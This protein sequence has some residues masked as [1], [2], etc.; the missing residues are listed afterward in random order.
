M[1]E[2]DDAVRELDHVVR[3]R[4]LERVA[5][6][7]GGLQPAVRAGEQ[8]RRA[9]S[10]PAA[11]E[12]SADERLQRLR[13]RQRLR[14]IDVRAER[15]GELEREERVPAR[16]LVEAE[17]RRP[18]EHAAE[19]SLQDRVQ[20][21]RAERADLHALEPLVVDRE[22]ELRHRD[23]VPE[24]AGEEQADVLLRQSPQRERQSARRGRVEP[25]DVVD[26]DQNRLALASRSSALRTATASVRT[27]TGSSGPSLE[28]ERGLERAAPRAGQLRQH[29]GERVLEQVSERGVRDPQLDLAGP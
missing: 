27:S 2:T 10:R 9:A 22:L 28:Q 4:R 17:Q 6:E 21:A 13:D 11:V 23:A 26:R 29:V 7:L 19:P 3:E 8:Q 14:R 20:R 18:R 5:V 16:G 12:P 15:A 1:R 25:L 24:P